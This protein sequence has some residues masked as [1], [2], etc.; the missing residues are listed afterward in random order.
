MIFV[1]RT[2]VDPPES[3][4][5]PAGAG[6]VELLAARI[7]YGRKPRPRKAYPFAAYKGGDVKAKLRE[8]FNGKCAYCQCDIDPGQPTDIEHYRPK[9]AV[10]DSQPA[11]HGYWWLAMAWSNLLASCID[12]NRRRGQVTV[13][14][15]MAAADLE[16]A[17]LQQEHPEPS[18][19][20]SAFPTLN[21]VWT[22]PENDPEAQE[23][24]ALID[25][26]RTDPDNHLVW[27]SEVDPVQG[28][29]ASVALED[30]ETAVVQAVKDP[31]GAECPRATASIF[32][33]GLNR[34][35]LVR[36]R[37]AHLKI[38]IG[39]AELIREM[40]E[41]YHAL[42]GEARARVKRRIDRGVENMRA[43][44]RPGMLYSAMSK[45]FLDRFAEELEGLDA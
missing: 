43:L 16:A 11:H 33:Y 39:Q 6:A 18:G 28:L 42:E 4:I 29:G 14:P 2:T 26:T 40:M 5:D 38:L 1:D 36:S 9:G 19:K 35:G 20:Q 31:Q 44:C 3:L 12:C 41:D 45:A 24:A 21:G 15:G 22:A 27:F 23:Q 10:A 37:S 34:I 17:Y 8:L 32:I 25:P 13:T 7:H 30:L